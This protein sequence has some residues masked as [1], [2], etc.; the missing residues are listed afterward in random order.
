MEALVKQA[1]FLLPER[2]PLH[3]LGLL[4]DRVPL[5]LGALHDLLFKQLQFIFLHISHLVSPHF[6]GARPLEFDADRL[7]HIFFDRL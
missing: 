2:I 7:A 4:Q 1:V 6:P 3:L 5:G